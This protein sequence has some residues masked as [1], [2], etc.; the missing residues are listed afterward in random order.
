[1]LCNFLSNYS[2]QYV[3][4]AWLS[5]QV[6]AEDENLQNDFQVMSWEYSCTKINQKSNLHKIDQIQLNRFLPFQ[7]TKT[8]ALVFKFVY[9]W[10]LCKKLPFSI[11]QESTKNFWIKSLYPD[12]DQMLGGSILDQDTSFVQFLGITVE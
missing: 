3:S 8:W 11:L 5:E 2:V 12:L 1:M 6:A 7:D 10:D 4:A 9:Y